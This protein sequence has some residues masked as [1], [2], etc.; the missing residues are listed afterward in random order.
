M[1]S[2]VVRCEGGAPASN[3]SF[4]RRLSARERKWFDEHPRL[5]IGCLKDGI[6][7]SFY[8]EGL[9]R[10]EGII[11]YL[12]ECLKNVFGVQS[13]IEFSFYD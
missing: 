12:T 1:N 2:S 8:D 10:T 6:P 3:T 9:E 13:D 4:T 11:V 5:R 7:F